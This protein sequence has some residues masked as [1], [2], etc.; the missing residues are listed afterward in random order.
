MINRIRIRNF[1]SIRDVTV[2]LAPVTV[3]IGKSGTGKS[4]F[5]EAIRFLR[6]YLLGQDLNSNRSIWNSTRHASRN[7]DFSGQFDVDFS[8]AG[9]PEEFQYTVALKTELHHNLRMT[10]EKLVLGE[11]VL[12]SQSLSADESPIP[13]RSLMKWDVAPALVNPIETG[14][15]AIR[16][17]SGIPDVVTAYTLLTAGI[18][19]YSFHDNLFIEQSA[20]VNDK[21]TGLNDDATN[22]LQTMK[23][24]VANLQDLRVRR[25]I[26][27]ALRRVN[28]NV[29]SVELNDIRQ[30]TQALVGH[31]FGDRTLEL[32]LQQ[33]SA[34]FR[35]VYAYLLALYQRPPKQTLI[36][37]HPEDGI[38]PGALAVLAEEF[39]AAPEDTRGQIILTTHSPA[40]LDYFHPDQIRV[41]ELNGLETQIGEMSEEQYQ[42]ISEGLLYSGELLTVDPA[43]IRTTQL[44]SAGK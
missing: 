29:T 7:M 37:E 28:T 30:P 5:V 36:F 34:G 4:A 40:L 2:D 10:L 18:G 19:C 32:P 33:E 42:A 41:V 25:Q 22:Y 15:P 12:F 8:I 23:E 35:R 20:K 6:N 44:E 31:K 38:H 24:V 43:R 13:G 27:E 39:K 9:I 14:E 21:S 17:I 3:L 26:L 11:R 16:R 1:K